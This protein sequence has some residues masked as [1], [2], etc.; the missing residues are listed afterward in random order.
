MNQKV[1]LIVAAT[2]GTIFC[3]PLLTRGLSQAPGLTTM[4]LIAY[5]GTIAAILAWEPRKRP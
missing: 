2:I 5:I 4:I 1:S 3:F